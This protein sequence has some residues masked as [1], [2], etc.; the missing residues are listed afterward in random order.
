ME[1]PRRQRV[2]E[3][4]QAKENPRGISPPCL[5]PCPL[6]IQLSRKQ[7]TTLEK[8]TRTVCYSRVHKRITKV[9]PSTTDAPRQ[10]RPM[11]MASDTTHALCRWHKLKEPGIETGCFLSSCLYRVF[12]NRDAPHVTQSTLLCPCT[13]PPAN[14]LVPVW[15]PSGREGREVC[16]ELPRSMVHICM[17]I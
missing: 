2:Y 13:A 1:H 4:L 11:C 8:S 15:P 3:G 14:A 7:R 5:D 12:E 16:L 6:Q 10:H 17:P 9:P